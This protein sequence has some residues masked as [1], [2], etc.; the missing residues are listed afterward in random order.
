[1]NL[2]YPLLMVLISVFAIA[3]LEYPGA[4][5]SY[6]GLSAVYNLIQLDQDR[7][8]FLTWAPTFGRAFD[9]FRTEGM[10]P[11]LISELFH[12]VGLNYL[13]SVKLVYAL[14]WIASGLA[15]YALA[16]RWFS[17]AGA[18]LAAT[19]YVYLPYH[20]ADVYVA[21]AFAESV[22][23][24]LFPLALS[25]LLGVDQEQI[26]SAP[27]PSRS[28]AE[29][30]PKT[31]RSRAG[32]AL[33]SAIRLLPFA[34][35]FLIQPGLAL[36]FGGV[37][38]CII[39][40]LHEPKPAWRMVIFPIAGGLL[41]GSLLDLPSIL[42]Y[43]ASI[44]QNGFTPQYLLPY[45]LFSPSWNWGV[46]TADLVQKGIQVELFPFQL[47]VVPIGLAIAAFALSR[48]GIGDKV[49]HVMIV[50]I[51]VAIFFSLLTLEIAAPVWNV[52]GILVTEPWQVLVF[53]SLGLAVVS[54]AVVEFDQRLGRPAMLAFLIALPVIASYSYL[55]PQFLDFT[56][57]RPQ[58]AIFNNNEVALLDYRIVGPLRHGATVRVEMRWQALRQIDHDYTIFV[59][60][61]DQEGKTWGGKDSKPQ[62]GTLPMTKWLPGQVV[63][64]THTIQ[65]N[66]EGPREG[67]HLEVGLYQAASGKRALLETGENELI[68]PRPGDPPPTIS[69]QLPVS[70]DNET[71]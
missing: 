7:L 71:N 4:F 14:A 27:L 3:P 54:G 24:A 35:L 40:A 25:S 13:D 59:H 41:V 29:T 23:W 48:S 63:S 66:V 46:N 33:R 10:L 32:R 51:G 17:P 70:S 62:D 18:L 47:G 43:G 55:S 15:M 45:Q 26:K 30:L 8:G 56:P 2:L 20:I 52:L 38:F 36:V 39:I 61:V 37:A 65:I 44:V 58:I 64:D 19:V 53:V 16:R 49:L 34:A 6:S 21:G 42:H 50:F 31:H 68:L 57:R 69:D 1:M 28:Q 11:Y 5:Q 12:L 60:A 9:L 67:Y 22:A